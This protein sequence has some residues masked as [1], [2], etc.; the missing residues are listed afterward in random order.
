MLQNQTLGQAW[1][2]LCHHL[3]VRLREREAGRA[4]DLLQSPIS[5]QL[6]VL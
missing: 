3:A 2:L 6:Y 4:V 1:D 5:H